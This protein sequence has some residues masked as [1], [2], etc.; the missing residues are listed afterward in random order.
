[1]A[2]TALRVTDTANLKWNDSAGLEVWYDKL[3]HGPLTGSQ[4][5][6]QSGE[7]GAISP[8]ISRTACPS[9][10]LLYTDDTVILKSVFMARLQIGSFG[11]VAVRKGSALG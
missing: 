1:M 2:S 3:G 6:K 5:V 9:G 11:C 7:D 4:L 8:I 10:K